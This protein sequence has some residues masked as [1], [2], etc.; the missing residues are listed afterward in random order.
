MKSDVFR[1]L[2]RAQTAAAGCEGNDRAVFGGSQRDSLSIVRAVQSAILTVHPQTLGDVVV[3]LDEVVTI[4]KDGGVQN[5]TAFLS[6]S[7][8]ISYLEDLDGSV[9]A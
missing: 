9:T 1:H 3:K 7:Q 2:V 6:L 4:L 8:C 5:K